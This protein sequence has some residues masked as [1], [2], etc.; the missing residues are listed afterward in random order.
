MKKRTLVTSALPYINGIK[1]LGNL[2]G[3]L[4]PADVYTR[5]LRQRGEEVLFVCGT[6]EHG[7]PA[8]IAAAESNVP[9]EEYCRQQYEVQHN[10]Y[11]SFGIS[12]DH[13]GRSSGEVNV[14]TT[15]SIFTDLDRNG[16]VEEREISMFYSTEDARFLP[17]RYVTG[18][19]PKCGFLDARGDQCDSCG[20][21]LEPTELIE[22]R[23]SL[24][25]SS[26]L[27]LKSTWHLYLRLDKMSDQ[28][29][30]WLDT[31]PEWPNTV[32]GIARK[33][34][35]EG[36]KPRGIT[37]DLSWGVPVPRPGY[38]NK[39][40]YVWFDAPMAYISF[41]KEWAMNSGRPEDWQRWWHEP[42]QVRLVQFM[43]KDNVPFHAIFWPAMLLGSGRT[44][45]MADY[46]KGFNWLTYE[47]GKFSTSRKRGV[48]TDQALKLYPADYWRYYLCANAPESDDANFTFDHFAATINKDLA[49]ILGNFVNRVIGLTVKHFPGGLNEGFLPDSELR[50]H[51]LTHM[52]YF[53]N[54]LS[55][56]K[57]RA[58]SAAIR[59]LWVL[60]NE[61]ITRQE[62]WKLVRTDRQ[63]ASN[64]LKNCYWLMQVAASTAW[65]VVPSLSRDL[66]K[67][68]GLPDS[69]GTNPPQLDGIAWLYGDFIPSDVRLFVEKIQHDDIEALKTA[70][71]GT[72]G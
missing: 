70:Y 30:S 22:P 14:E 64:V 72:V 48:F 37:R 40:F 6:D 56:L 44:W 17:D 65:P 51:M 58:A 63:A 55:A 52:E 23:S 60:G 54:S 16:L 19:C 66:W 2:V 38:T 21:L 4:L 28:V 36:L 39:V 59:Q 32:T 8:E 27:E 10:I 26:R 31:H 67:L 35:T 42:D 33:W 71:S 41:T 43:A 57:I 24:S 53:D 69:P 18:T 11:K 25:G 9:V 46:I 15:Q 47:G 29:T 68:L 61:Y 7:T 45:S 1:H 5:F 13:F 3:S 49:D 34:L 20:S 50:Q 12:F 62:P